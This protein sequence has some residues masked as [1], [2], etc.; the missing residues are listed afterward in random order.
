MPDNPSASSSRLTNADFT[1]LGKL[2]TQGGCTTRRVSEMPNFNYI[3]NARQR[4]AAIRSRLVWL[5]KQGLVTFLDD[6]K[7]VCWVRTETGT[8]ALLAAG[9]PIEGATDGG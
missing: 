4:T 7:P 5:K 9:R 8:A 6:L 2:D 1:I 3:S